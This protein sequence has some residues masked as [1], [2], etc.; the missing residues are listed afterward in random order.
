VLPN[1]ARCQ[2]NLR[3]ADELNGYCNLFPNASSD[4]MLYVIAC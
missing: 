4:F 2:E 3:E 1:F